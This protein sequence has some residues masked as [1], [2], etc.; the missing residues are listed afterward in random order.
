MRPAY[1]LNK[2]VLKNLSISFWGVESNEPSMTI[3][4]SDAVVARFL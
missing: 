4:I 1:Y 3:V 2:E